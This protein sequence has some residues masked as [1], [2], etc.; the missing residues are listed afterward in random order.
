V[1]AITARLRP[2]T[3]ETRSHAGRAAA[4]RHMRPATRLALGVPKPRLTIPPRPHS[5]HS[6][7]PDRPK[8][9]YVRQDAAITYAATRLGGPLDDPEQVARP[10]HAA[11]STIVARRTA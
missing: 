9:I 7:A 8:N 10:L 3:D 1:Q 11:H 5:A 4:L 6:P 2:D